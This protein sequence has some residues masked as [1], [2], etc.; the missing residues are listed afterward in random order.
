MRTRQG[1]RSEAFWPSIVMKKWLNIKPKAYDFSEDE[2]DT[3]QRVRMM[4]ALLRMQEYTWV[5]TMPVECRGTNP[6]A[7]IKLQAIFDF[8]FINLILLKLP[9][10]SK[11]C[12][13]CLIFAIKV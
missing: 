8:Y 1:K 10:K 11:L 7:R 5:R 2:V 13:S 6:Y 9:F 4:L 3:E 12:P